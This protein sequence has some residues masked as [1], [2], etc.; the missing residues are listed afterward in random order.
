MKTNPTTKK[1][2]GQ[3]MAE[4]PLHNSAQSAIAAS[5]TALFRQLRDEFGGSSKTL[6]AQLDAS[7]RLLQASSNSDDSALRKL[8]PLLV[9]LNSRLKLWADTSRTSES[10]LTSLASECTRLVTL[11][12]LSATASAA[13]TQSYDSLLLAHQALLASH[14]S[15]L[16]RVQLLETKADLQTREFNLMK[17]SYLNLSSDLRRLED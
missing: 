15:L 17:R 14:E 8:S 9:D 13:Q 6:L 3:L 16:S 12:E 4:N 11:L 5:L 10:A 7:V 2:K 1:T